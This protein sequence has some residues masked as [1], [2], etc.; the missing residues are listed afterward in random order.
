MY[1]AIQA[2]L[3]RA[4]HDPSEGGL[5]VALAEMAFA[6]GLG[7]RVEL[8]RCPHDFSH[9]SRTSEMHGLALLFSES[10]SRFVCEIPGDRADDFERL[11]ADTPRAVIGRVT[12]TGRL[13]IVDWRAAADFDLS[14]AQDGD[15]PL[16]IDCSISELKEA[17]QAPLR[18]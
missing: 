10:N 8:S 7:A 9:D 11:L 6:G 16:M 15:V 2:G 12:D 18:W 14:A 13:Q 3:V 4:C 1:A 17:W 5:A